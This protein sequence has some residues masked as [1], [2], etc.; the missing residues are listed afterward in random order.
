[1]RKTGGSV[2]TFRVS[3]AERELIEAI[4]TREGES[5]SAFVRRS[6]IDFAQILLDD[7]KLDDVVRRRASSKSDAELVARNRLAEIRR[8]ELR[9]DLARRLPR[10]MQQLE[11]RITLEPELAGLA[12][13]N[14]EEKHL[15]D[16]ETSQGIINAAIRSG[17]LSAFREADDRFHNAVAEASGEPGAVG[18]VAELRSNLFVD[19]DELLDDHMALLQD[20]HAEHEAVLAAISS[21][22]AEQAVTSMRTHLTATAK[23]LESLLDV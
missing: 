1:M 12:A 14:H 21:R 13:A 23:I 18:A 3:P 8:S 10:Y 17:D 2:I 19:L 6:A 20:T 11:A 7:S 22:K 16:L 9:R 15:A 5:V 4:A